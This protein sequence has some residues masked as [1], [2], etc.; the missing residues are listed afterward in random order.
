MLQFM[1]ATLMKYEAVDEAVVLMMNVM[2]GILWKKMRNVYG[3][4]AH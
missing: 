1:D 3:I 2:K 4:L